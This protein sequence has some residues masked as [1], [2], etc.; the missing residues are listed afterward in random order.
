MLHRLPAN[1]LLKGKMPKGC[2]LCARGSKLVLLVT[3][4]CT[5][6]CFYCPLSSEKRGRDVVY[7]DEMR[8]RRFEDIIHEAELI[9]AEGAGITGG[10][11][12]LVMDRTVEYI[13]G[14]KNVF[15]ED[16]HIHLYTSH[17]EPAKNI[18][19]LAKTGLDEIRFHLLPD[20][21]TCLPNNYIMALRRALDTGMSVGVEV[22]ALPDEEGTLVSLI[23][24]LDRIGIHFINLNELEFSETNL[25]ALLD[26]GYTAKSDISA[27][28]SGSEEVAH[29]IIK[30]LDVDLTMHYCSASFKDRVQL[31][32]RIRRRARNIAR[33]MDVV[34]D[35]GTLLKGV[36]EG[37]T[38]EIIKRLRE[39][40]IPEYLFSVDE[41]KERIEIAPWVLE[42]IADELEYDTFIVEE[43]PT[44]DRL[45]T[46]RHPL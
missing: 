29:R 46:E 28:V 16:F 42:E 9:E 26:R 30:E 1:C 7:A 35:D 11:P 23:K 14:L 44:A 32:N 10:D 19:K 34:T 24:S 38:E 31:R 41:E 4:R 39:M 2:I 36:I 13:K 18:E 6:N 21:W 20:V 22:P 3:G 40:K 12:M 33:E 37:D 43:Y 25:D 27:A 45:E 8:V 5:A 17:L 15:G